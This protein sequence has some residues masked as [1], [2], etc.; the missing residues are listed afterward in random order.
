MNGL[1]QPEDSKRVADAIIDHI[2][3]GEFDVGYEVRAA[4]AQWNNKTLGQVISERFDTACNDFHG[5]VA[6]FLQ[7]ADKKLLK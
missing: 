4:L 5:Q 3:Q 6:E 2:E 1:L 7:Q